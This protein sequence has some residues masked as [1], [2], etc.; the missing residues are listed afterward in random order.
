M[1]PIQNYCM[2]IDKK[3]QVPDA[4]YKEPA[5]RTK[6]ERDALKYYEDV[7][8]RDYARY[9]YQTFDKHLPYKPFYDHIP[10]E[11][12]DNHEDLFVYVDFMRPIKQNY[13][14]VFGAEKPP[15]ERVLLPQE[16]SN[17]SKRR[18]QNL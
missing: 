5:K 12:F 3:S 7:T 6:K 8:M 4:F 16:Y 10:V 2:M 13:A 15:T 9:W 14:V 11:D 1:L 18:T 17:C